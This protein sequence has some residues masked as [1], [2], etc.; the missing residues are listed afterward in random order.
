MP[1]AIIQAVSARLAAR[2]YFLNRRR[3]RTRSSRCRSSPGRWPV[4]I[5]G[6]AST[7]HDLAVTSLRRAAS[8]RGRSVDR[9]HL[10]RPSRSPARA[11]ARRDLQPD[12]GSVQ[13]SLRQPSEPDRPPRSRS[14][15][16]RRSARSS[17]ESRSARRDADHRPQAGAQ[18][19]INGCPDDESSRPPLR[20]SWRLRP[21]R[22]LRRRGRR[23]R[24]R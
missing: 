15:R 9:S 1:G 4:E 11:S 21:R 5:L 8:G 12:A 2:V 22:A 17:A 23:A 20:I 13:H 6:F 10:A 19:Q 3:P 16:D 7:L 24:W 18:A 14:G